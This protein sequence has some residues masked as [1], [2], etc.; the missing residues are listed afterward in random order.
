M[1][2]EGGTVRRVEGRERVDV[3][4]PVSTPFKLVIHWQINLNDDPVG[5]ARLK[6]Q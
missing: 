1:D 3:G 4:C 2:R 5:A 6:Q